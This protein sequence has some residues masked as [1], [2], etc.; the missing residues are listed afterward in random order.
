VNSYGYVANNPVNFLD[1]IGL[2]TIV[3]VAGYNVDLSLSATLAG[4]TVS[5]DLQGFQWSNLSPSISLFTLIGAS[6]D[7]SIAAPPTE[8]LLASVALGTSRHTSVGT[9]VAVDVSTEIPQAQ[10]RGIN[11]SLGAGIG[12]EVSAN[13]PVGPDSPLGRAI[14]DPLRVRP[15]SGRK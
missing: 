6:L 13:I 7:V 2:R 11:F 1:P 5:H 14:R 4:V 10:I 15:L 8:D 9:N 12:T 3:S